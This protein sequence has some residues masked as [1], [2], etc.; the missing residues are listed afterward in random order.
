MTEKEAYIAF[1]LLQNV[2]S[3]GVEKL[4]SKH[5]G[6]VQ[7]WE[8]VENKIGRDGKLVNLEEELEKAQKFRMV[9]F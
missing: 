2:G 5:G 3:V 7:A 9:L 4:V 6:I 1:N 8:N